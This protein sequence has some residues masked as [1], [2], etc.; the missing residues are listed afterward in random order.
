MPLLLELIHADINWAE[1]MIYINIY[2]TRNV[3][4]TLFDSVNQFQYQFEL[5][6]AFSLPLCQTQ[7]T[8]ALYWVSFPFE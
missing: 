6:S 2:A 8:E 3:K 1:F 5:N 4:H 7:K